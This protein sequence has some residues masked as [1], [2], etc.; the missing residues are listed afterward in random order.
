MGTRSHRSL[1]ALSHLLISATLSTNQSSQLPSPVKASGVST[2]LKA[3]VV[4]GGVVISAEIVSMSKGSS[5]GISE[6]FSCR[7]C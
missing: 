1:A 2:G 3:V 5:A 6:V 7:L 4:A